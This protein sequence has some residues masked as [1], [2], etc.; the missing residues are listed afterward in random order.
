ML[1]DAGATGVLLGHSERRQYFGENDEALADKVPAALAAG[2]EPILCVGETGAEREAGETER[3]LT[4]QV[5]RALADIGTVQLPGL[6]VAY[7]P[8]WAIGTGLTA[9]PEIAQAAHAHIRSVL[10]EL[11]G[12]EAAQGVRIQYGGSM[13]PAN[14]AE[15]LAQPDIDGGLIGGASPGRRRL[16][17]DRR[18]R[19]A[20]GLMPLVALVILDGFGL[21]PPGPGNAVELARTPV[22]DDLWARF[23]HTT[24]AASGRA[25]GPAGRPDGELRGRAP[26]D[27]RRAGTCARISC[28]CPT[29]SPTARS[30]TTRR[31]WPLRAA[32]GMPAPGCT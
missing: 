18:G 2:L 30:P 4:V 8:V 7:E 25:V 27:R 16:R 29:P 31:S 10:A 23:P 26:D 11:F 6:T 32:P 28:A 1:V 5:T 19:R 15:L 24:L 9:T 14:A 20:A 22:F 13:K 3:R 12:D 17:G 21:A